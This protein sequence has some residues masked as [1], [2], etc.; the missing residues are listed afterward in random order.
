MTWPENL[1]QHVSDER[2]F[3]SKLAVQ[4]FMSRCQ[5]CYRRLYCQAAIYEILSL[6]TH[7]DKL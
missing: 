1:F 5:K 7:V 6:Y 4:C 2:M 3:L